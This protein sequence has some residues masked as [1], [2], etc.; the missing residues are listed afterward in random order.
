[1]L[2]AV[3]QCRRLGQIPVNEWL[4]KQT[5]GLDCLGGPKINGS[6]REPYHLPIGPYLAM[7][8]KRRSGRVLQLCG[9]KTL[10][11]SKAAVFIFCKT[12]VLCIERPKLDASKIF[13]PSPPLLV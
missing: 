8:L 4:T 3:A 7:A 6:E 10:P 1:V 12:E 9:V 2:L 11:S 5:R 13:P